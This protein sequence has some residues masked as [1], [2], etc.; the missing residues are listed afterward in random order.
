MKRKI[1]AQFIFVLAI[2]FMAN[3]AFAK[4]SATNGEKIL[5]NKVKFFES[6]VNISDDKK[7]DILTIQKKT[8]DGLDVYSFTPKQ[9]SDKELLRAIENRLKVVAEGFVSV[10][11]DDKN[12]VTIVADPN[13]ITES[14]LE[15]SIDVVIKI[16]GYY[17][18]NYKIEE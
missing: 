17:R 9:Q 3:S 11:S 8:K 6:L 4:A 16:Y 13:K 1:Y 14:N 2:F 7:Q 15:L 5:R 12:V 18:G 10:S